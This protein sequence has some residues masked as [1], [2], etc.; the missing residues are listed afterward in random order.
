MCPIEAVRFTQAMQDL[1]EILVTSC[2]NRTESLARDRI[3]GKTLQ[4]ISEVALREK[5][6]ENR[7]A[8]MVPSAKCVTSCV[9]GAS[10]DHF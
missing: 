6:C 10:R 8:P 5:S 2:V 3:F 1:F 4:D 9:N 7:T